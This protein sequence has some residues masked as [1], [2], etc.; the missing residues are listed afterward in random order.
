MPPFAAGASDDGLGSG[1]DIAVPTGLAQC[2]ARGKDTR[3]TDEPGLERFGEPAVG[4]PG[5]ADRR[6]SALQHSLE[7]LCRL[8][9]Q[10]SDGPIPRPG[11]CRI[12]G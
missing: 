5:I 4:A 2:H 3:S 6:E 8:Q 11:K 7:R 1:S 10:P 12:D 9:G